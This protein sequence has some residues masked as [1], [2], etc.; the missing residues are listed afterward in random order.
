VYDFYCGTGTIAIYLSPYVR[1]VIGFEIIPAAILDAR[2]NCESNGVTNCRFIEGDLKDQIRD[3]LRTDPAFPSPDLIIID[4]PRAG[5]H[6]KVIQQILELHPPKI[7]YVSCNPATLARD[8]KSLLEGESRYILRC[9]QPIDL[10]PHTA[11]CEAIAL[12]ARV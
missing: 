3:H 5:L 7:T 12:L 6:P 4:P 2:L 10:F 11:H 8:L 9:V 1:E